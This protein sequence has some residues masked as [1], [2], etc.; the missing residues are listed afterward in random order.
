MVTKIWDRISP[1]SSNKKETVEDE[2]NNQ[3]EKI[4]KRF[5]DQ[6]KKCLNFLL[7]LDRPSVY[8]KGD[9]YKH[10][11]VWSNVLIFVYLHC[12]AIYGFTLEKKTISIVFGW[13][14]GFTVALGT[15]VGAHRL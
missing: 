8:R 4:F 11:I 14:V 5:F 13:I 10:E 7:A 12:A 9:G 15:T 3:S 1:K 2:N 6:F